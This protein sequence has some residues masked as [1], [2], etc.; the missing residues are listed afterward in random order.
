LPFIYEAIQDES[1]ALCFTFYNADSVLYFPLEHIVPLHTHYNKP[2]KV[3][4][5]LVHYVH[6]A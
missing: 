2:V 6:V 1:A 5:M 4:H 3:L